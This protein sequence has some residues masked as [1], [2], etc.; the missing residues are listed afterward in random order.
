LQGIV[1]TTK[2]RGASLRRL[3]S[4]S[5]PRRLDS[6]NGKWS[7]FNK[8]RPDFHGPADALNANVV[9][10]ID[11]NSANTAGRPGQ[12][13]ILQGNGGLQQRDG[14][15]RLDHASAPAHSLLQ[16]LQ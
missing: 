9:T 15:P 2:A 6:Q 13:D 14:T 10:V 4:R 3:N 1:Q 7:V 5:T 16:P 12:Y 11:V 8:D